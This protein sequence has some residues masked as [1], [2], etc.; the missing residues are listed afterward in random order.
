MAWSPLHAGLRETDPMRAYS[1]H[2]PER[3]TPIAASGALLDCAHYKPEAGSK[4]RR[5]TTAKSEHAAQD[6]RCARRFAHPTALAI[7]LGRYRR[8]AR[9]PN[10][11]DRAPLYPLP[12]IIAETSALSIAHD[13]PPARVAH[14]RCTARAMSPSLW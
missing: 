14:A 12:T 6:R 8:R 13:Q 7:D 4:C 11:R 1:T 2:H 3:E 9:S 10:F 5:T